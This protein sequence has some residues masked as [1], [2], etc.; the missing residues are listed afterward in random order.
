MLL[1]QTLL[2]LPAQVLGP[3]VQFVSVILWTYFLTPEEMGVFALVSAA[4]ELIGIATLQWFTLYT[5]R[6]FDRNSDHAERQDFLNT[7]SGVLLA[8]MLAT[9]IVV[10]VLPVFLSGH[11]D[12]ALVTASLAYCLSRSLATHLADRARTSADTLSYSALQILWPAGG[13]LLGIIL[14]K[15][16]APAAAMVLWGYAAA[17]ILALVLVAGR[18]PFSVRPAGAVLDMIKVASR[19]GLPLVAGGI[20]VWLANNGI[21]FILERHS[22]AAAVGLV[23]VG[24]GLGLRASAFAAMLVTAAA[25]PLAV[26]R[27][28]EQGMAEGQAQLVINGVLLLA[29]L[30]PAAAGFW[31]IS[32]PLVERIVAPPYREMTAEVLPWAILAG[33]LRN[34]R[35]HFGEQVFLLYENTLA[36]LFNNVIDGVF[37]LAGAAA[38]LKLIGLSGSVIGAAAGAGIGTFVTLTCGA[39]W[40]GFMLPLSHLARIGGATA[41]MVLLLRLLPIAPATASLTLAVLVGAAGYA[42]AMALFYPEE[43]AALARRLLRLKRA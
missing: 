39:Y 10:L 6:Y 20:F 14:V 5:V 34:L 30:A 38:G 7:E 8:G 35:V 16:V 9:T 28:R 26:K 19:Y 23:A 22:G 33:A 18:M 17:Q 12:T 31:A 15:T 36:S 41:F 40:Y 2:Y 25:F 11:W 29:V 27:S 43:A 13:L 37:T 32:G 4:Q 3:I 24:W 42:G 21:R 1:R